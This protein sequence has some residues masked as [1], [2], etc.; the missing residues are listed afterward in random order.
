MKTYATFA[1]AFEAAMIESASTFAD[2]CYPCDAC[3][4]RSPHQDLVRTPDRCG[5]VH[6]RCLTRWAE[7][8]S[9]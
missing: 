6:P 7:L 3:E 8:V 4:R 2:P 9:E 5:S 1:E